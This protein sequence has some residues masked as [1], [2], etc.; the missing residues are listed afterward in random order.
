MAKSADYGLGEFAFPRGWFVVAESAEVGRKP[1]NVHYFGQDMVLYRGESG[2]VVMLDAYCPHMGTHLGMSRNSATV[3]S[4]RFL[5]GDSIRCP[6]HAWRFGPDGKCNHIPYHDG[7]IPPAARLR[8]WRVEERYGIVFCWHDPEGQE[9]DFDLP[10]YAEWDDPAWVRWPALDF[11]ADLNHPI[12]VFDNMSDVA[13]INHLHGG[14]VVAY[15]NEYDG[16]IMHQRESM[17]TY[18]SVGDKEQYGNTITTLSGYVGPGVAFGHFLEI[19]G[20]QLILVTPIDDGTCRL[21][22]CAMLKSPSGKVDDAARAQRD[23]FNASTILGLQRDAEVWQHK[24][25][26]TQIMQLPS[27]GPFRQSRNWY[28]QF[29]NPREKAASILKRVEGKQFAKGMPTFEASPVKWRE[30]A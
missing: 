5:E 21:W 25:A 23:R 26:A 22:Q 8:S 9:P 20:I 12:E 13:H 30:S 6:F 27:D 1:F 15:E 4:E 11:L 19:N 7:P 17:T 18:Q 2:R 24:R 29:Y 14:H 16:C 3:L 10:V 28:S